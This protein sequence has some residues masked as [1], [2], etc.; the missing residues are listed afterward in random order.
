M[1]LSPHRPKPQTCALMAASFS[2]LVVGC[3]GGGDDSTSPAPSNMQV[4]FTPSSINATFPEKGQSLSAPELTVTATIQN[5]PSTQ[6]YSRI[7]ENTEVLRAGAHPVFKNA[8]GSFRALLPFNT[9]LA[10]GTY[11]GH[12][13]LQLCQDSACV[14]PYA[15]SGASLPYA[16]T[17]TPGIQI[18]ATVNGV[19][20]SSI[21]FT[22]KERDV[23]SLQSS[24]AVSWGTSTGGAFAENI[25]ST[26]TSWTGTMRY[27]MSTPGGIGSCEVQ[28]LTLTAPQARLG[29]LVLVTQ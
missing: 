1:R 16:L 19:P 17:V 6:V 4:S 14:S 12:L 27:A 24:I 20:M 7:L 15:V 21:P 18:T 29:T 11:T 2:V 5:L 22:V 8:D 25:K 23:V 28:A 13:T 3:G 10:A 26:A 9:Q